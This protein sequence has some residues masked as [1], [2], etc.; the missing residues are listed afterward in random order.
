MSME[1]DMGFL[2]SGCIKILFTIIIIIYLIIQDA[3]CLTST[4]GP[5]DCSL[6]DEEQLS[7]P[8]GVL[9]VGGQVEFGTWWQI[10]QIG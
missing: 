5:E 8:R 9:A 7:F 10:G 4:G 6:W 3:T 2:N 1:T